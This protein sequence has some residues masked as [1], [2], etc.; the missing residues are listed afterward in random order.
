MQKLDLAIVLAAGLV[1]GVLSHYL[2]P[3]PALA[4]TQTLPPRE[5][6][7]QSFTLADAT[8]KVIGTFKPS[9]GPLPTVVFVDPNGREIWRAGTSVKVLSDK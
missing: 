6:V 2:A 7:A 4:Q 9:Y 3:T 5:V 8:G 1:G